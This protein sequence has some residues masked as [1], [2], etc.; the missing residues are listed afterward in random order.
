MFSNYDLVIVPKEYQEKI[1]K[2][3]EKE[4]SLSSFK[5][6]SF[7]EF[8]KKVTYEYDEKAIFYLMNH[9][10]Y[11]REVAEIIIQNTYY[12]EENEYQEEKLNFLVKIKKELKDYFYEHN[13][14][15]DYLKHHKVGIYGYYFLGQYEE[16]ILKKYDVEK[17]EIESNSVENIPYYEFS[18]LEQEL[19][20][21]SNQ[22]CELHDK[23]IPYS[24]ILLTNMGS[25]YEGEYEKI[26]SFFHI[27]FEKEEK[28]PIYGTLMAHFVLDHLNLKKE[29]LEK[30]L[31]TTFPI[32]KNADLLKQIMSVLNHYAWCSNLEEVKEMIIY[33]F[34]HTYLK[35]EKK[36]EAIHFVSYKT[37]P[38]SDEYVFFL[39]CNQGEFP[40]TFKD[41]DYISDSMKKETL[42]S[43]TVEKNKRAM[44]STKRIVCSIKNC[45]LTSK[46]K[47]SFDSYLP[48]SLLKEL[49]IEKKEKEESLIHYSK[50]YDEIEFARELDDYRKYGT[51]KESL[52]NLKK[53]YPQ[54]SYQ[55]YENDFTG[56]TKEQFYKRIK[57]KLNLSYTAL[58]SYKRCGFRYYVS[59]I[60][61]CD[62]FEETFSI[63]I[64]NLFHEVLKRAFQKNFD[65]EKVFQ[66]FAEERD[67]SAKEK[68]FL[69]HLKEELKFDIEVIKEQNKT[70]G[71]DQAL[72]EEPI[73]VEFSYEIPVTFHGII[74]KIYYKDSLASIIDYKTG[75]LHTDFNQVI[76]GINM[77]LP[78]YYYL[79]KRHPKL[80][81]VKVVGFYLQKIVN[82]EINIPEKG[83][84][85]DERKKLLRLTGY[86]TSSESLLKQFDPTYQNST[87]IKG[88]RVGENGFYANAKVLSEEKMKKLEK[89]VEE[90]IQKGISDILN[91]DFSIHPKVIGTKEIGCENCPYSDI[92]FKK[93]SDKVYLKEYKNAEFLE[94]V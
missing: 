33:D 1:L 30:L 53:N 38:F 58:D 64:G 37:Y 65:F 94:E 93:E 57:E 76:Y 23:G 11:K 71:F 44:V 17:I 16:G 28:D 21:V 62:P 12:V 61:K 7:N 68:F 9:Y 81:N 35:E 4:R 67:Y 49:P 80:Q 82:P 31:I 26:F 22:I 54:I 36:E 87:F 40:S 6:L 32:E 66:D 59:R 63:F 88:M 24:K 75:S 29:E 15:K 20:F 13:S 5:M 10:H 69:N 14:F 43:N 46:L 78:I 50:L 48:S 73:Q 89:C 3:T 19:V 55:T 42:L 70:I 84:R 39:G 56:I 18:T 2:D 85:L 79:L 60:L 51:K 8:F 74:D 90:Q 45:I 92:C 77:Q 47:S 91:L 86:S 83:T 72:Y 41:E 34:L 25:E 52:K 27:P